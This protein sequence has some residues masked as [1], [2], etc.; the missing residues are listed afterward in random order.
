HVEIFAVEAASPVAHHI[1]GSRLAAPTPDA[2]LEIVAV[3]PGDERA[4]GP[5]WVPVVLRFQ[6]VHDDTVCHHS[7]VTAA[8]KAAVFGRGKYMRTARFED[9]HDLPDC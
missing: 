9:A 3:I 2:E 1:T 5:D 7:T 4:T 8:R 6:R